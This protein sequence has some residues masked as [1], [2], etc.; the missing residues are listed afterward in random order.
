[1]WIKRILLI[2]LLA[3]Q[4]MDC[5]AYT[6]TGTHTASGVYPV[7]GRTVA[8]DHLPFGTMVRVNGHV[9]IVEDRFGAGHTDKLDI[10]ME[11]YDKAIQFGRRKIWIELKEDVCE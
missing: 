8:C 2:G 10:F 3:W 1:M 4:L 6:P 5:T 11:S 7:E 9:Y